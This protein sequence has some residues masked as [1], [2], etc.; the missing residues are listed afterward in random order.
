VNQLAFTGLS[1]SAKFLSEAL[2]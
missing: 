2:F 1:F